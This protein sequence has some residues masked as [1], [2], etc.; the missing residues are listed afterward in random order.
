MPVT[1]ET[2]EALARFGP[3]E[4]RACGTLVNEGRVVPLTPKEEAVLRFLVQAEGRRVS[5]DEIIEAVWSDVAVSD[6]SLTRAIHTLRR[7]L[8]D[9]RNGACYIRTS[10]GRGYQLAVPVRREPSARPFADRFSVSSAAS[11]PPASPRSRELMTR[12]GP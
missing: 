12:M 4:L 9:G 2:A 11:A 6:A 8:G 3:F 1:E 5:K 10:Y 7:R